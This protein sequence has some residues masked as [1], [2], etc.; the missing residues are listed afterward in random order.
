MVTLCEVTACCALSTSLGFAQ[1]DLPTKISISPEFEVSSIRLDDPN[2]TMNHQV[3]MMFESD[4][5]SATHVTLRMLLADMY[6]IDGD[7]ILGT[8]SW[9]GSDEYDIK[10]RID[11]SSF[12]ILQK[13]NDDQRKLA[14]QHMLQTLLESR[15]QLKFHYETKEMPVYSL[16]IAR[17]GSKLREA[18]PGETY[19]N[20]VK[21]FG[22]VPLGPQ[23]VDYSFTGG[24]VVMIG[25]DASLDM[26]ISR[27]TQK[28][29]ALQLNRKIVDNTGLTGKYDFELNFKVPWPPGAAQGLE[30]AE[31]ASHD[32][33]NDTPSDSTELSLF[34]ALQEQLGLK[35]EP[36][37]GPVKVIVVDHL[38]K[39]S[40]N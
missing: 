32:V 11:S 16:V 17:H 7:Q 1:A 20:G 22:G 40:M 39:P 33:D 14:R 26:L 29:V 5:Y 2:E 30:G 18:V 37:K 21:N 10:A 4:G 34:T 12:E 24:K 15:F 19:A 31:G 25:Q 8:P 36:T 23:F 27:L 13:L 28:A 35:L 9:A 38:E 3:K 6:G